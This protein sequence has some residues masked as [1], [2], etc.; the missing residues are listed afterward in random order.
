MVIKMETWKVPNEY[1]YR[2]YYGP[3][4]SD[5]LATPVVFP[6]SELAGFPLDTNRRLCVEKP[7]CAN[8]T[9]KGEAA[10][11]AGVSPSSGGGPSR[12]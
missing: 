3:G 10:T 1:T 6:T 12:T 8:N 11:G 5:T 4:A 9:G 2:K 7:L